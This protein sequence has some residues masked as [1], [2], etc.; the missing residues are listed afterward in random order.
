MLPGSGS[1]L[2]FPETILTGLENGETHC[3]LTQLGCWNSKL[4]LVSGE[5]NMS[6]IYVCVFFL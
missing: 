1:K 5:T 3:K 4:N 6:P 2:S